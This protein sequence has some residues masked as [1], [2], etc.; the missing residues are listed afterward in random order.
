MWIDPGQTYIFNDQDPSRSGVRIVP[1]E[2]ACEWNQRGFGVFWPVN[3]FDGLRRVENLTKINGWAIDIDQGTKAE[4]LGKIRKGLIP[5]LVIETKNGFHV[6]FRAS[7]ATQ[8]NWNYILESYLLPFYSAD[9]NAKDVTRLLRR[10]GFF[11]MKDPLH[12]FLVRVVWEH[13]VEYSEEEMVSFFRSRVRPQNHK[14]VFKVSSDKELQWRRI[15]GPFWEKVRKINCEDGLRKLSGTKHVNFERYEFIETHSGNKNI[16]VN[17]K[18][19][20]SFIDRDG[21]I[22]SCIGGGPTIAQW[23]NWFHRDYPKTIAILKEVFTECQE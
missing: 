4:M 9:K 18:S 10:P 15:Y 20:R 11:H 8:E 16:I 13:D 19:I 14:R 21:Y 3:F 17:G 12:P 23:V 1:S 7:R 22:G 6:Y 5:T 2:E